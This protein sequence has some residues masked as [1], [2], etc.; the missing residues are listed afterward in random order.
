VIDLH[1]AGASARKVE[2]APGGFLVLL[3]PPQSLRVDW[4]F[5]RRELRKVDETGAVAW[6]LSSA[7]DHEL[8]D[9]AAHPSGEVTALFASN[10][11][12]RLT[13]LSPQGDPR[14]E[15]LLV[16]AAIDAD[17]PAKT[18]GGPSSQIEIYSH[19][20][21][22][23]AALG[24]DAVVALRTGRH[25]VITHRLSF[26]AGAFAS[27]FRSVAFPPYPISDFALQGGTYDT[28]GAVQGQLHVHLAVGP[29]GVVYVGARYAELTASRM[30]KAIQDVFGQTLDTDPDFLDSYVTRLSPEGARLGVSVVGT[31]RPDEIFGLR[32]V[33]GAAWVLGR[34]ELWNDQGTGFDALVARVDAVT[35]DV[36]VRALDVQ[37]GDIA[38]DL[39]RAP[40]PG[41]GV[42]VAGASGYAQN[43]NGASITEASAPFALWLRQGDVTPLPLPSGPRHNE[44]L[45]LLPLPDGRLLV[46]GMVDGPGTHSADGDPSLLRADGFLREL[47]VPSAGGTV[48]R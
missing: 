23:V 47:A 18:A 44:A 46:G 10:A 41:G 24:E 17:V 27:R 19:D 28:F 39:A 22:R 20:C 35:G 33:E 14:G 21:G 9:F 25:S 34:N 15:Q 31:E 16:D 29:E 43:P 36:L 26:Q 8:L 45:T 32:A 6:K 11:G 48:N 4:G 7:P 30:A 12:Y 3:D 1:F 38:F 37:L 5:P 40:W 42:V 13:R 2:A